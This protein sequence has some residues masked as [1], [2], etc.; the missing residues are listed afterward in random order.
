MRE[1][2]REGEAKGQYVDPTMVFGLLCVGRGIGNIVSGPLSDSL[3]TGGKSWVGSAVGGFG[4][5]YGSLIVYTGV[6]AFLGGSSFIW[7]RLGLL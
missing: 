3:L 5:S 6:T 2:V 7:K 4:S 1:V